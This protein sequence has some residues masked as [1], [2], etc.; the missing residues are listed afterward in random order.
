[1]ASTI[2]CPARV[3]SW[4]R[5]SCTAH[6][7]L[8]LKTTISYI[9][10]WMHN[11]ASLSYLGRV[12]HICVNVHQIIIGSGVMVSIW[13]NTLRN[14]IRI[15]I[16]C[17]I[18]VGHHWFRAC[19]VACSAPSHYLN[20]CCFIVHWTPRNKRSEIRIEIQNFSFI[21]MHLKMSSAE[22]ADILFRPQCVK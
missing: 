21:K 1:M 9:G 2:T 4:K 19:F 6:A 11:R 16:L 3:I 15:K 20:Q 17:F 7:V 12:R 22:M 13:T 5:S 18:E 14:E 10:A 8:C